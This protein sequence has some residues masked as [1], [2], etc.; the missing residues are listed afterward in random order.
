M[1]AC[2]AQG[3]W[4][5]DPLRRNGLRRKPYFAAACLK[6]VRAQAHP[7]NSKLAD[8]CLS[9]LDRFLSVQGIFAC[10]IRFAGRPAL[11]GFRRGGFFRPLIRSR[12]ARLADRLRRRCRFEDPDLAGRRLVRQRRRRADSARSAPSACRS[13]TLLRRAGRFP[14]AVA[15][16]EQGEAD[17]GSRLEEGP[18]RPARAWRERAGPLRAGKRI[19]S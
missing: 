2:V 8:D 13:S 17:A 7:R 6:I 9:W 16:K 11:E 14:R 15:G 3:K 4:P 5:A 12:R 10:S 18:P 19:S 1:T